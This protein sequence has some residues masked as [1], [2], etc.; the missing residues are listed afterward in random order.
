MK[1]AQVIKLRWWVLFNTILAAIIAAGA[2]GGLHFIWNADRTK[3]SFITL[4]AFLG[5]SAFIG[6]LTSRL[7]DFIEYAGAKAWNPQDKRYINAC[8][9]ASELFMGMGIM[10]TS[11]GIILMFKDLLGGSLNLNDVGAAK[12]A[13]LQMAPGLTTALVTTFIGITTSMLTKLQLINYEVNLD[14]PA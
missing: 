2:T 10:G 11:L 14:D 5:V 9:F 13:L 4:A 3:I 8:W 6:H 7:R 12:N 1:I